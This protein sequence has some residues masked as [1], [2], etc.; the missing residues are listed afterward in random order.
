M[1]GSVSVERENREIAGHNS[2]RG[3]GLAH[4]EMTAMVPGRR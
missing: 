2:Q 4:Q 3:G 1:P